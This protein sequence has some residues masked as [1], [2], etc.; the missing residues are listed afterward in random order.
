MKNV[1]VVN[2]HQAPKGRLLSAQQFIGGSMAQK[3]LIQSCQGWL[4]SIGRTEIVEGK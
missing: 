4:K 3:Y 1:E 2:Q